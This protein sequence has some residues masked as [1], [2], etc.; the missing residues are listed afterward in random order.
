MEGEGGR[1]GVSDG[2][3]RE[4]KKKGE[5]RRTMSPGVTPGQK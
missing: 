1:K 5:R 3:R 2:D 4:K